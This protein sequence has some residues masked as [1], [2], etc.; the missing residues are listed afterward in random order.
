MRS[1][2][3][4]FLLCAAPA[5]AQDGGIDRQFHASLG[6]IANECDDPILDLPHPHVIKPDRE[7]KQLVRALLKVDAARCPGTTERAVAEL[8]ARIGPS[9]GASAD[10]DLLRLARFAAES[11]LGMAPAP[12]LAD[13]FGR[14]LWLFEDN[15]PELPRL[16]DEQLKQWASGPEAVALLDAR[17]SD[18]RLRTRRSLQ[19][20]IDM[21]L[22]RDHPAYDPAKAARLLEDSRMIGNPQ[23]RRRLVELLTAGEHLPADYSRSARAYLSLAATR[24]SHSEPAQRELLRIGRAAAAAAGT[25]RELAVALRILS[26]SA[27][28]G[29][30]ESLAEQTRLRRRI[31]PVGSGSLAG[32]Q[33]D[34]VSDSLDQH[35]AFDLPDISE[36][37]PAMLR[38]IV[39]RGLIG[40]DGRVAMTELLQSSGS[41]TR[42]RIVRATWVSEGETLDLSPTAKGRFVW[43]ELPA[44]NPKL[45]GMEVLERKR[46]RR[47]AEVLAKLARARIAAPPESYEVNRVLADALEEVGRFYET[48]SL[49]S[50]AEPIVR[51]LAALYPAL[52]PRVLAVERL[53]YDA[54]VEKLLRHQGRFDEAKQMERERLERQALLTATDPVS[55]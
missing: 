23:G 25:P 2:A 35:M 34:L 4:L 16:T 14:L 30:E 19:L 5:A 32:G 39:L 47:E 48:E 45:T 50:K 43:A 27:I 3:M 38:P 12:T 55:R 9:P 18:Q 13:R 6:R 46:A 51:E 37:D 53:A 33:A 41:P 21:L 42:D 40:P 52:R 54:W 29:S 44:V 20:H 49:Y 24:G 28:D 26:A 15:P 36:D 22:R 10:L 1:C 31:G 17:N 11:G 8:M 7:A